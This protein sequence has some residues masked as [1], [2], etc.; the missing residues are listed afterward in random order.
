M[1]MKNIIF[2]L[3]IIIIMCPP[4]RINRE[5]IFRR[6]Q[7]MKTKFLECILKNED[8]SADLKKLIEENKNNTRKIV[9]AYISELSENDREIIMACRSNN[10]ETKRESYENEGTFYGRYNVT[11]VRHNH[12]NRTKIN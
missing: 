8:I 7:A 12:A 4:P 10:F 11:H 1:K 2:L 3:L 9:S 6:K 5:E